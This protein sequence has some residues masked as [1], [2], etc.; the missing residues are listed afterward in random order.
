M[1]MNYAGPA[2]ATV[3]Q[4][5]AFAVAATF[6]LVGIL[7][8]IPGVTTHVGDMQFAGHDSGAEL[9]GIFGVSVLHNI[10][11]LLFGVVG[12][13]LARSAAGA[14]N[15]LIGGGIVYLVLTV[16][17]ALID[18]GSSANFVPVNEADNWLHLGLGLAMV[19]LGLALSRHD[20]IEP[21][22]DTRGPGS[23]AH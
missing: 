18:R 7:G 6:L 2:R 22:T 15:F 13:A 17:G 3:L 1:S 5:A 10:V 14:R 8:F 9:L 23:A 4:R 19:G 11:H 20:R 16:Y 12:L 21:T